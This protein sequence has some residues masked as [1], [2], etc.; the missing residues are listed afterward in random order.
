MDPSLITAEDYRDD[1]LQVDEF[2]GMTAAERQT[3]TEKARA[4]L[5]FRKAQ[6]LVA[7]L[8]KVHQNIF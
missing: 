8:D 1:A 3:S 7:A 5:H 6:A 2:D 4:M